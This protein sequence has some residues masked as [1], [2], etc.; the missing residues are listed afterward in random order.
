[1]SRHITKKRGVGRSIVLVTTASLFLA[2]CTSTAATLRAVGQPSF[3]IDAP[4]TAVACTTTG[5]CVTLGAS[6][7]SNAP[8]AAAQVRNHKGVWSALNVPPAPVASFYTGA[9]AT[10]T[11]YFG[12]TQDTGDLIWS[13]D[14]DTGVTSSLAGPSSGLVIRNLSCSSDFDCVALDDAAHHQARWST[15]TTA[16]TT[17]STPRPLPWA[18]NVTTTLSCASSQQCYVATTSPQHVVT[19]RET[20]DAGARWSVV[21]TPSTWTSLTSLYCTTS[22]VALVATATGSA[23]ATPSTAT[24]AMTATTTSAAKSWD[25]TPIAF[26]PASLSCS[27]A[28]TCVVVGRV[29]GQVAAMVQ[30]QSGTVRSVALTYVPSALTDVA[31]QPS[32]CVAIGVTT[33]V[34]LRP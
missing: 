30:W 29:V 24:T 32:V 25:A 5:A 26:A 21:T 31:C 13:I 8:T 19:L 28:T 22:C 12:G 27:S 16:G 3:S 9:C 11:C 6:G 15:T 17:W 20:L 7:G 2:S 18:T 4:L 34:S 14:V 33:V 10:V 23:V 1:M